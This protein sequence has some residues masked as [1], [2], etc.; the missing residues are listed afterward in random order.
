MERQELIE[1]ANE[2]A[3]KH[4]GIPYDGGFELVNRSWRTMNACFEYNHETGENL[5][6][7]SRK[8]NA[9]RTREEVIG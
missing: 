1:I 2:L 3:Q 4:W 6:R 8:V 9:E 7:M 5:I